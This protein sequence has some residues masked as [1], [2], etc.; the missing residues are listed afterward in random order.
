MLKLTDNIKGCK[1]SEDTKLILD[2]K[3]FTS[4]KKNQEIYKPKDVYSSGNLKITLNLV[5]K[6]QQS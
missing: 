4:F 5:K 3:L 6:K 2:K 1:K